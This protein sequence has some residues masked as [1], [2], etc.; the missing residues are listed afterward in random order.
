[1]IKSF[2]DW[3]SDN[4]GGPEDP[5]VY[6]IKD[7]YDAGVKSASNHFEEE[8]VATAEYFDSVLRRTSDINFDIAKKIIE[9][10]DSIPEGL[11]SSQTKLIEL[12]DLVRDHEESL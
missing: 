9:L 3:Y 10:A 4:F 7:T 2:D 6:T 8:F 11:E 12:K 5:I 1:M